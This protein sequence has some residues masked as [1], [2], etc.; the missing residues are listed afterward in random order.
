V[1]VTVVLP[2]RN[3]RAGLVQALTGLARQ[4]CHP[5]EILVVNAGSQALS[6]VTLPARQVRIL[7]LGPAFPGAARNLGVS[8]ATTE[9]VAFLDAGTEP[10]PGWLGA[11]KRAAAARPNADVLFGTYTP[12]LND[13]WDWAAAATYLALPFDS[14][15][16]RAP[17]TASLCVRRAA[18][19]RIG[20]MRDDLRAGEDLLF[21]LEIAAAQI[22]TATVPEANVVWT[23]PR[24]PAGHFTRLRQYSSATWPTILRKRWQVPL[25]RMYGLALPL[26]LGAVVY[27]P[28]LLLAAT[29]GI[30][31]LL[32]NLLQRR[33][34]LQSGLTLSRLSRLLAM[35]MLADLGTLAGIWDCLRGRKP[36]EG[37]ATRA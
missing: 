15:G 32:K 12:K 20:G 14:A 36:A 21:F 16:N 4:D 11:F 31:R 27:R 34:Y 2:V 13:E 5:D 7:T 3:D 37:P 25:L 9:W 6:P 18:W 29:L 28:F 1:R 17:T 30:I 10:V 24:G 26:L 8:A 33:R 19:Q 22:P 23:L 35:Y